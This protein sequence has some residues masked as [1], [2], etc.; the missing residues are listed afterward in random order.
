M[1][2]K[3]YLLFLSPIIC[4]SLT[5]CE[6]LSKNN[7]TQ[8]D[9]SSINNSDANNGKENNE[10]KLF[11]ITWK[12]Y[13][14]SI[15]E[16]DKNVEEGTLPSYDGDTPIRNSDFNFDYTF[17]KWIPS[18]SPVT[19]D[20]T[21]IAQYKAKTKIK[22]KEYTIYFNLDGGTSPSFVN[23]K[24]IKSL[25]KNDFFYDCVKE[26]WN[27]RGWS[28]NGNKVVD[29]DGKI[30]SIPTLTDKMTFVA[31]YAKTVRMK[32]ECTIPGA[33]VVSGAGEYPYYST[34]PLSAQPNKGYKFTGWYY[35]QY[36][37]S[38]C[39]K[40][41]QQ[42]SVNDVTF[43]AG[44]SEQTNEKL[45]ITPVIDLSNNTISYG[46]YPQSVVD[47]ND[48]IV[49]EL[50]KLSKTTSCGWYLYNNEYYAK[51]I[52]YPEGA[53]YTFDN[54]TTIKKGTAYWFKC[55]PI[56]W[57]ILEKNA[58]EYFVVSS[59][60]LDIK[61]YSGYSYYQT[62]DEQKI[63]S[64]NYKYSDIRAWLNNN[65]YNSAFALGNEHIL[66][67]NVDNSASTTHN[68]ENQFACEN[69]QD[70]VF[71]LSYQDYINSSY[72]FSTSTYSASTRYCRTTDW[73]RAKGAHIESTHGQNGC[74]WT[75][76]PSSG[77]TITSSSDYSSS[78]WDITVDGALSSGS[79]TTGRMS[80][81]PA[82]TIIIA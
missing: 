32:I 75:R 40:Y 2:N 31:Q 80:V 38:K 28:Y 65:F 82:I 64:C 76:S 61:H 36:C 59:V 63:D 10:K 4:L 6:F 27:F 45:G 53:N 29:E 19:S 73:T 54:N 56:V 15:L 5:S 69:T 22:E 55:E 52:A 9:N 79:V 33:G 60:L 16:T 18:I 49:E 12:N 37:Y 30:L 21:Y 34:V 17:N 68:P 43:Y 35:K 50:N 81:R 70:K 11:T 41:D 71:L 13:D 24:K 42:V 47:S 46:L 8:Y 1:K 26:G 72:G 44:F 7:D 74:Y 23:S 48:S 39:L 14:D 66:I 67:T 25:T 51:L 3:I 20:Q 58:N 77:Y 57:N 78:A 62:I